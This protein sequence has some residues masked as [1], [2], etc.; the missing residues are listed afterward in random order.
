MDWE[1]LKK[2]RRKN[3]TVDKKV[4][5]GEP[6]AEDIAAKTIR[7]GEVDLPVINLNG[8]WALRKLMREERDDVESLL[9]LLW[10]LKNQSRA[11]LSQEVA[12]GVDKAELAKL[13][14][15]IDLEQLGDYLAALEEMMQGV[16]SGK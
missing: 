8:L 7:C 5:R 14:S 1:I 16:G 3:K 12:E 2:L 4:R 15:S 10:V 6:T 13:A 11:N 9:L